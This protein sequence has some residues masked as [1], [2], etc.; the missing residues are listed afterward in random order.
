VGLG[1]FA[2]TRGKAMPLVGLVLELSGPV[3]P[4]FKISVETIFLGSPATRITGRR[5]VASGPTGREPLVGLRIRLE[6]AATAVQPKAKSSAAKSERS[7]SR[8]RVFRSR[9]NQSEPAIV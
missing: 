6:T 9:Q 5:V 4:N 1:S 3:A 7:T 2:G 8:V